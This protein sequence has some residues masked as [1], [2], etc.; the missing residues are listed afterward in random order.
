MRQYIEF[1]VFTLVA[2]GVLMLGFS[3]SPPEEASAAAGAGGADLVTM[4]ASTA[5][6]ETMVED[7]L[8]PPDVAQVPDLPELADTPPEMTPPAVTPPTDAPRMPTPAAP[9]MALP[10]LPQ[11]PDTALAELPPPP[12]K[13]EPVP[14][15]EP[16]VARE[17]EITPSEIAPQATQRPQLRPAPPV[18]PKPVERQKPKPKKKPQKTPAKTAST[19]S[20][21]SAAQRAAG[22]GGG[23]QAGQ[24]RDGQT[25]TSGKARQN[26][27]KASWGA[28]I[29]TRVERL[30][31]YPSRAGRASGTVVLWLK[32]TSSG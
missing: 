5:S 17:P 2:T 29:R 11:M 1:P 26:S 3:I 31:R 27:L 28:A 14:E 7:W 10:E 30:K 21:D 13:P 19:A 16:E 32:V 22:T 24:S 18:K 4:E 23:A 12:P 9:L 8:K 6:V 15:P 20:A 25:A